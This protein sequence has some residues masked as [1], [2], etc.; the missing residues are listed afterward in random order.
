[1]SKESKMLLP[2]RGLVFFVSHSTSS[3]I[4]HIY[5]I[6]HYIQLSNNALIKGSYYV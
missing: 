4:L 1:M 3:L 2:L 6:T 5:F